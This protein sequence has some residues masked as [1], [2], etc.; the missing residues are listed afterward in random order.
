MNFNTAMR[1]FD[2]VVLATGWLAILAWLIL[3][4]AGAGLPI[5]FAVYGIILVLV[6]QIGN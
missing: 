3:G 5:E 2:K 1:Y 4:G 6:A